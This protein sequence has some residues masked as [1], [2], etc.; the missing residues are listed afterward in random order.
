MYVIS[1]SKDDSCM[2]SIVNG[3]CWCIPGRAF[4][5]SVSLN[6]ILRHRGHFGN[7]SLTW[8]L[9]HNGSTLKPGEEFY[10]TCGTVYFMDGEGSKP[11]VLHALSDKIPEFNEFYILKLVNVSGIVFHI[12]I[13][14]LSGRK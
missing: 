8:Q 13:P 14:F 3:E 2:F 4:T 12:T 5:L 7:V 9:F 10:E 6:R 1:H 11:I